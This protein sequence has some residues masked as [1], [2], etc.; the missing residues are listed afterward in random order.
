M[1]GKALVVEGRCAECGKPCYLHQLYIVRGETWA[2]AG[3]A[4]WASGF[5][6]RE[7]LEKRLGRKLRDDELL[8]RP[9]KVRRGKFLVHPDYLDSPEYREHA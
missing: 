2:A 8:V 3:M 6:H 4:G 7:C 9:S 1:S 5:L